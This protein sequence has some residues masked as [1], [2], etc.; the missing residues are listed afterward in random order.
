M[1]KPTAIHHIPTKIQ[2]IFKSSLHCFQPTS[3]PKKAFPEAVG[4]GRHD[5]PDGLREDMNAQILIIL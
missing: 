5:S 2:L 1:I 3:A 4:L